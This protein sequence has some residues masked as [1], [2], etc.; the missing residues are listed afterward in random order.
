MKRAV[1]MV[2]ALSGT[3]AGLIPEAS[4]ADEG[5]VVEVK[6]KEWELGFRE[7]T[8]NGEKARFEIENDGRIEHAF[9][10]E[11]AIGSHEFEVATPL[12]SPGENTTVIVE[13]PAG[14]YE[15]YCPV[16]GHKDQ[17]MA[18]KITFTGE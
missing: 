15:V 2:I 12:L 6:L 8:V 17:G 13:L 14:E 16:P 3:T 5:Q 18:A 11:G 4:V 10:L 9:E 1:P 7:L